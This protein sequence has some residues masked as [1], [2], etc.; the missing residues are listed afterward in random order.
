MFRII[1]VLLGIKSL[2]AF[3]HRFHQSVRLVRVVR[4]L[5]VA[6][7]PFKCS[8]TRALTSAEVMKPGLFFS[9]Q[10]S[11]LSSLQQERVF[12]CFRLIVFGS[13]AFDRKHER[14]ERVTVRLWLRHL[15]LPVQL[16]NAGLSSDQSWRCQKKVRRQGN[17]N[18]GKPAWKPHIT[19]LAYASLLL[20]SIPQCTVR[21]S[22]C[23]TAS[24]GPTRTP[25]RCIPSGWFSRPSQLS[26][27][28]FV[29]TK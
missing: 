16:G 2:T 28:R 25:W 13:A 18:V 1:I 5:N 11:C 23:L 20:C 14:S 29:L 10:I 9:L 7:W 19:S 21:R 3:K 15:H 27:T 6:F 26:S 12:A 22:R 24:S 4:L 17:V 8:V